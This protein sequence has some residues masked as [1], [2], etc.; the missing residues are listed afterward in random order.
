MA[1]LVQ[2]VGGGDMSYHGSTAAFLA[3]TSPLAFPSPTTAG[4][5]LVLA[6]WAWNNGEAS[7][8]VP[9]QTMNGTMMTTRGQSGIATS[10]NATNSCVIVAYLANAPSLP[11]SVT[12]SMIVSIGGSLPATV[13][14]E[15][16]LYEFAGIG[17]NSILDNDA[18]TSKATVGGLTPGVS[19][20]FTSEV[21]LIFSSYVS[22]GGGNVGQATGYT[23]GISAALVG[24]GQTQYKFNVPSGTQSVF[25]G[26][27]VAATNW[28]A[29]TM[30]W[31]QVAAALVAYGYGFPTLII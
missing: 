2:S 18:V 24:N 14:A 28:G 13:L 27:A 31:T 26:G 25:F 30:A 4:S 7:M 21:D 3:I 16:T 8:S 17:P 20:L 15:C 22:P 5:L 10:L 11:T 12:T 6:G 9:N 23:L 29:V 1:F 19:S